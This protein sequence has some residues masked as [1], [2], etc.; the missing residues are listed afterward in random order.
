MMVVVLSLDWLL[1]PVS[2]RW[3]QEGRKWNDG[4]MG[5]GD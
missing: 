4:T 5:M 2:F 1:S 3:E